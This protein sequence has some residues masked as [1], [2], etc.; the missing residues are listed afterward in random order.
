MVSCVLV[1]ESCMAPGDPM[2]CSLRG[3][4]VWGILKARI[5][6]WVAI[7]FSRGSSQTRDQTHIS[8]LSCI[9]RQ[10]FCYLCHQ[11]SPV[12][13]ILFSCSV[14]SDSLRPHELQHARLPCSSP[15]PGVCSNSCSLSQWCHPTTSSS[16]TPFSSCP[17][18]FPTSGSFSMSRF[19][20]SDGQSKWSNH[21]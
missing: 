9:R 5:L 11:Q 10:I 14:M 6:E 4:S 12:N 3:S 7:P 8:Y 20:A 19:L 13:G 21:I 15:S 17:Q 2:D 16:V 18:S 1:T